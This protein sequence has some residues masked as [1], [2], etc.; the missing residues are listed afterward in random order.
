MVKQA[1]AS[2]VF[3]LFSELEERLFVEQQ[4]AGEME[5]RVEELREQLEQAD[6][7]QRARMDEIER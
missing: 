2:F 6:S 1:V 3:C 5:G 4:R 7:R